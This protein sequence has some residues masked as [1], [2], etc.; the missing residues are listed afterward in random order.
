MYWAAKLKRY[1]GLESEA[2][3]PGIFYGDDAEDRIRKTLASNRA[4]HGDQSIVEQLKAHGELIFF[5]RGDQII[6]EGGQDCEVYF[7][8]SGEVDIVF[9]S[10]LGSRREAPNQ[11]GEMAAIELGRKRSASVFARTNEVAALKVPGPFFNELWAANPRFQ[12][13]LQ[14][15]MSARHRE[16]IVA[17]DIARQNNSSAWFAI[18]AGAGLVAGLVTWLFVIPVEWTAAARMALSG[19]TGLALFIFTLMHNP[20]FFWKRCFGLV[21]AAMIGTFTLDQFVSIEANQGFGSLQISI[22]SGAGKG[23]G[24][25][26]AAAYIF[27]LI[28]CACMDYLNRKD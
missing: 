25:A 9:K 28:L 3:L 8:L 26:D 7:L 13:L 16:R 11:I 24:W 2:A 1:L 17:G 22:G 27:T 4:I 15:E 18:S 12:Q 10:Q 6:E 19:G 5:R 23:G 14:V 20:A 21:L